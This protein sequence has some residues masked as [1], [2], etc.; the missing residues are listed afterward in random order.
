M[1]ARKVWTVDRNHDSVGGG[2]GEADDPG[3]ACGGLTCHATS[4]PHSGQK[5]P[6]A[7]N[8]VSHLSHHICPV[9]VS[10]H[11]ADNFCTRLLP[12]SVT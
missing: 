8:S 1:G 12:K 10:D 3:I 11:R 4:H 5:R 7:S 9:A 6:P 2:D